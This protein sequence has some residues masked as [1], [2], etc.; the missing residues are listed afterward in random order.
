MGIAIILF[1]VS[2]GGLE[3]L[4]RRGWI[5]MRAGKGGGREGTTAYEKIVLR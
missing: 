5:G 2:G 3:H 4:L 1:C